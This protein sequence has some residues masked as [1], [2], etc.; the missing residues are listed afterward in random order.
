[1]YLARELTEMSYMNIGAFFGG[2]DHSTVVHACEKVAALRDS[3][4]AWANML[5]QLQAALR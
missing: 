2:R 4:P 1:M 3:D 5:R